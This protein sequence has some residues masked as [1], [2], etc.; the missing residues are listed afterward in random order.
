MT[1]AVSEPV[2]PGG[3]G[4]YGVYILKDWKEILLQEGKYLGFGAG[5][6]NNVAEYL[7]LIRILEYLLKNGYE[8]DRIII[9]GDSKM[10]VMQ[11]MDWWKIKKGIYVPYAKKARKLYE[12]L[13]RINVMATINTQT[14]E[15]AGRM[16]GQLLVMYHEYLDRAYLKADKGITIPLSVK[17]APGELSSNAISIETKINFSPDRI[18]D[19][20]EKDYD[21]TQ[22]ILFDYDQ[23]EG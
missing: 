4:G 14:L 12:S 3:H 6:S 19:S 16:V 21:P 2:N 9:Y 17:F 1:A 10:A 7:G 15:E 13:R 11:V 20:L 22:G 5:M 8:K 18:K 23:K